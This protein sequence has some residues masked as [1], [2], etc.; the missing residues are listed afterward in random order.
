MANENTE[1]KSKRVSTRPRRNSLTKRSRL[2][3]RDQDPNFVYRIVNDTP[4][5]VQELQEQDWEIDTNK[6]TGQVVQA[7]EGIKAVNSP[8][9]VKKV[10]VGGGNYAIVMKKRRDYHEEDTALKRAENDKYIQQIKQD[11]TQAGGKLDLSR[12]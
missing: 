10:H 9:S 4:G 8:G 6:D 3:V 1:L 7:S 11:I 12:D 5:R 2:D